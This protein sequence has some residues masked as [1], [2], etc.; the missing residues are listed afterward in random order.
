MSFQFKPG[1]SASDV[2]AVFERVGDNTS[3]RALRAMRR[4]AKQV[5][6]Q[7][8]KNAPILRGDLEAA[9]EILEEKTE[10]RRIVTTVQVGSQGVT[11]T[12]VDKY[13]SVIE[14]GLFEHLGERS[15]AKGPQVGPHFLERA[16]DEYAHDLPE[17]LIDEIIGD[18]L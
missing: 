8:V 4:V 15:I 9:H 5:K 3:K 6:D 1:E 16:F 13:A 17:D 2:G 7:S 18:L 12:D 14:E 10:N 11:R